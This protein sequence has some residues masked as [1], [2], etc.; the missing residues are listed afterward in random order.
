[1]GRRR[2]RQNNGLLCKKA[3]AVVR[4]QG[5]NNA[6]HTVIVGENTYKF[7]MIPSGVIC[8]TP[9]Y[10][11][12]G[13]VIDPTALIAEIDAMKKAVYTPNIST[14]A[15]EHTLLHLIIN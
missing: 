11:A 4:F 10:I 2:K 7:H 8:A 1:M 5:G 15:T 3:D 9:S 12:N 6:G 14:S 13:M